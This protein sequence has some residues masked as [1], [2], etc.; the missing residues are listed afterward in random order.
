MNNKLTPS[1]E[2]Y[3]HIKEQH[4]DC[5]LFYRMGDFY[6]L[7]FEDAILASKILNIVL[8]KRGKHNGADIPMCGVPA[9]SS[10]SYLHKLI[11]HKLK[12]A[13]CEQL[14]TPTQA[15]K[16]GYKAIIKRDVVQIITPGTIL[17]DELLE[18]NLS[19]YILA[20]TKGN[21]QIAI[22]WLDISTGSFFYCPSYNIISDIAR[23]EPREILIS[24][25]FFDQHKEIQKIITQNEM[26]VTQYA[27]S[28][29]KHKKTQRTL[30]DFY[31]INCTASIGELSIAETSA[32]G[33][34]L[35]Y[36]LQTQK[37]SLSRL[38]RPKLYDHRYF[39]HIDAAT[40]KSLELISTKKNKNTNSLIQ[41]IDYT[42][43]SSGSRLLRSYIAAPLT[44]PTII[45]KRLDSVQSYVQNN[46]LRQKIRTL[47]KT[48]PD[49]E[50]SISRL[51]CN[52]GKPKDL[53]A[54]K[55]GLKIAIQL[56]S[57]LNE[58]HETFN[59]Y[60]LL[61][62]V[63]TEALNNNYNN[64]VKNGGFINA[65]FDPKLYESEH[66][67][68]NSSILISEL[69]ALY[70]KQIKINNLTISSNNLIGYYIEIPARYQ[71]QDQEFIHKQSL[72]NTAR[73]TTSALQALETKI[74]MA[75]ENIINLEYDIFCNL[76]KEILEKFTKI[77][78]TAQ[79]IAELDTIV[80]LAELAALHNYT[81]PII[82]NNYEF[83][84]KGGRHP[85]IER[86]IDSFTP[87][88][89]TLNHETKVYLL[90]G[91]N[92]AGKS[93]FLRQNA[94]IAIMAHIGS[95]VPADYAHIGVIDKIFSRVGASDNILQN[96]STFMVE[97]IETAAIV[98]QSTKK[99]LV[100][101]DE[102]GRGTALCDGLAIACA[103]IE[104]IHNINQC[105]AIFA[106]HYHELCELENLFHLLRCY[107]VEVREWDKN[108]IFL[109]KIVKGKS[110]K[111]YGIHVAKLAGL[112][113]NVIARAESILAKIQKSSDK[114]LI[115]LKDTLKI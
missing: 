32:C 69:E 28:F 25:T 79:M 34:L 91:P 113:R 44:A 23:I 93:T 17:E 7:F 21:E 100:I 41:A 16:R 56:S 103:V 68:T 37:K 105:R 82:D 62:Q 115:N 54:I 77:T 26:F 43:T 40:R 57:I 30:C 42:L 66:I 11:E 55:D 90:T 46:E 3:I 50:R 24:E 47:L 83:I 84:I 8:T 109:H 49:I 58:K 104:N 107:Y 15:K 61:V 78:L 88:D 22:S 114:N 60:N 97:M 45:N 81:K 65:N 95:F 99:S 4:K 18:S 70:K 38:N 112:P 59:D 19:N 1:M 92:M 80:S 9:H 6:E 94:L 10:T 39:L 27:D 74:V 31:N 101:L 98:N 72:A 64:S 53:H 35:E 67:K 12:I 29:F 36:V 20:I 102:I 76:S 96:Q 14:E 87:N 85:V 13:I 110:N 52:K 33:A 63:L 86:N 75:K 73:Y 5:L 71:I 106:T 51:S 2:Q 111:S 89:M 48:C 108:I